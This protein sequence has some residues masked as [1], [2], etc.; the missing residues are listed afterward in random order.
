MFSIDCN[1]SNYDLDWLTSKTN[2]GHIL[3]TPN[4]PTKFD[5]T[6]PQHYLIIDWKSIVFTEGHHGLDR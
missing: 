5:D 6:R 4:Q 3:V 1:K 2:G